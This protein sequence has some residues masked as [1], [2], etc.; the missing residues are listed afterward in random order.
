MNADPLEKL[1][2]IAETLDMIVFEPIRTN[3]NYVRFE[4]GEL[5][6]RCDL[7]SAANINLR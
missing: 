1:Q 6:F 2:R 7:L 3:H 5:L 4:A